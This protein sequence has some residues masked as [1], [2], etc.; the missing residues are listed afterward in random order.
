MIDNIPHCCETT[1]GRIGI[2]LGGAYRF[3]SIEAAEKF[4]LELDRLIGH[5]K[6]G[7]THMVEGPGDD[8]L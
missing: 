4:A 5:A 7:I 2:F 3:L 6:A 1:D 8:W